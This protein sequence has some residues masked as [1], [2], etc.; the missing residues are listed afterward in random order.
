MPVMA[1]AK[2]EV[3][4]MFKMSSLGPIFSVLDVEREEML[5]IV[6]DEAVIP[7]TSKVPVPL[8]VIVPVWGKAPEPIKLRVPAEMVVPPVYVFVELVKTR[9]PVPS[10]VKLPVVPVIDPP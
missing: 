5:P 4:L 1:A 10:K 9:S 6:V 3:E 8:S 7:L 2:V